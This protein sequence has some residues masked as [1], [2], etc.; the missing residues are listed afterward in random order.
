MRGQLPWYV[1]GFKGASQF[2]GALTQ[3]S[4]LAEIESLFEIIQ[5]QVL[6][7]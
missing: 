5:K 6:A 7:L 4:T 3:V 2:R 1:K